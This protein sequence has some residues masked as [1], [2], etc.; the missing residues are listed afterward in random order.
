MA[1]TKLVQGA[2]SC[3]FTYDPSFYPERTTTERISRG[4]LVKTADGQPLGH[5][6][7]STTPTVYRLRW[8]YLAKGTTSS[9]V[10]TE[11][12]GLA[13]FFHLAGGA[14][15]SVT[16]T[17]ADN[18]AHTCYILTDTIVLTPLDSASANYG[19]IALD[20]IEYA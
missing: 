19:P 9:T 7:G 5:A 16:Y 6:H 18:A 3:T 11:A 8:T 15:A 4:V 2:Y 17:D 12:L 1:F 20:L 14:G 10:N 13:N